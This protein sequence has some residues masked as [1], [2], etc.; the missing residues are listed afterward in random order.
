[1]ILIL[2]SGHQVFQRWV[3][4]RSFYILFVLHFILT[5]CGCVFQGKFV[6]TSGPDHWRVAA[7][8]VLLQPQ[9]GGGG[10]GRGRA[11]ADA[12]AAGARARR[13]DGATDRA[14]GRVQGAEAAGR[15]RTGGGGAGTHQP[16]TP[17]IDNI[18]RQLVT[19]DTSLDKKIV[20]LDIIN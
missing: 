15:H 8:S 10:V 2:W 3:R 13:R 7:A 19:P 16:R 18:V 20:V 11:H 12:D 1:M 6:R 5:S 17:G 4:R 9:H 14:A